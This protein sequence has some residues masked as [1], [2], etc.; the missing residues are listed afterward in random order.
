MTDVRI[1][2][3]PTGSAPALRPGAAARDGGRWRAARRAAAILLGARR[4]RTVPVG[5]PVR[6]SDYR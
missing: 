6:E 2:A 5:R 3:A 1:P 4:L